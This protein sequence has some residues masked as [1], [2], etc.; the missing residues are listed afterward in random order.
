MPAIGREAPA[1]MKKIIEHLAGRGT[2]RVACMHG[3]P[4]RFAVLLLASAVAGNLARAG[5]ER[6]ADEEDF[7]DAF[8]VC[9]S[10][11]SYRKNEPLLVG[12]PLWGVVGRPVASV[13]GYE[14]SRA[15]RSLGG[16]WD[17][18][19]L[20]SFLAKPDAYA[21]GTAMDM[22]GVSDAGER[23]EV[24]EFLGTLGPGAP[25]ERGADTTMRTSRTAGR[26]AA[27]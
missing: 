15:L 10:C 9:T 21:P 20:D 26:G 6:S 7:P 11:H 22:G 27:E 1:G 16:T 5:E 8:E 2:A 3:L 14:Y 25:E 24:V 17:L 12:P 4:G 19:R 23:A 13:R 18:A